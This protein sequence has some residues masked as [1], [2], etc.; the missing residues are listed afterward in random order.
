MVRGLVAAGMLAGVSAALA[1]GPNAHA[2][3]P[4]DTRSA[5]VVKA[6]LMIETAGATDKLHLMVGQSMMMRGV[7]AMRRIYVG[8]P[9][10]L[11][12]FTAGPEE[13]VITAKTPGISSLVIWDTTGKSCL[14]TV[15]AD[16]DPAG[17]RHALEEAYPKDAIVVEEA[18]DR[19]TLSGVVPTAEAFAGAAKLAANYGKEV[20]NSLRIVPMRGK[21]I[22]LKLRIAEVDRTKAEQFGFNFTHGGNNVFGTSTGQF[23]GSTAVTSSTVGSVTTLSASDPLTLFFTNLSSGYGVSIQDLES[24]NILQILAEPNLTTTDGQPARFLSGGEFPVPVAQAAS[25]GSSAPVITIAFKPYGVKV[26]FTPQIN[27]DGTIHLKI[28]PE[29]SSLD[30]TNEVEVSGFTIPALSTRRAES[31]VDLRDGQSFALTGLLD[32]RTQDQMAQIPGIANIPILGQLFRS[33]NLSHSTTELVMV[34][35]ATVVDPANAPPI[36][37]PKF[38]LTPGTNTDKFD[39]QIK[40]SKDLEGI[41]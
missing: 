38:P 30:Y 23:P 24:R 19:V 37:E 11:Q 39:T 34:V 22:Q 16:M 21:Q 17:L 27:S 10:V 5:S 1:Q 12:S 26:D 20:V 15:S 33:K 36:V 29:V 6:H 35:T 14:Y 32:R 25:T 18:E 4:L 40:P 2:S 13:I 9:A 7:S 8:N 28:A 3:Q 31:E 41:H